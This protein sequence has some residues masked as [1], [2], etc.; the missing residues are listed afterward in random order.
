MRENDLIRALRE[1]TRTPEGMRGIGDDCCNLDN[2]VIVRIQPGHFHINP[3]EVHF[4]GTNGGC[5]YRMRFK[6]L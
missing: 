4:I 3:D 5:G 1:R 2:T 6:S